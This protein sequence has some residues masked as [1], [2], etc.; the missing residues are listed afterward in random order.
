MN[1]TQMRPTENTRP[2]VAVVCSVPLLGEAME[3]ALDFAHVQSFS[4][5]G[6]DIK[7]LLGWLRPDALIVDDEACAAEALTLARELQ[8]PVLYVSVRAHALRLFRSGAWE[9]VDSG[10]GPEPEVV[11]NVLAGVLFARRGAV[12]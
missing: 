5:A 8:L 3:A 6:G 7:G 2:F 1:S 12:R 11:R 4:A 10:S 9:D